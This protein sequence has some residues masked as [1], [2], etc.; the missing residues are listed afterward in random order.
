MGADDSQKLMPWRGIRS[1]PGRCKPPVHCKINTVS[2]QPPA[3]VPVRRK[4]QLH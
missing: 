3:P 1:S 4:L 2:Q